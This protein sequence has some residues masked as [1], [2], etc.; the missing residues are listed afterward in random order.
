MKKTILKA[1]FKSITDICFVVIF[2]DGETIVY[3]SGNPTIKIIF[4]R[5]IAINFNLIDPVLLF[6][7]AYADG[8]IDIEGELE[9]V[10]SFIQQKKEHPE[11][12]GH[13]KKMLFHQSVNQVSTNLL[14]KKQKL[15]IQRHYDLGNDFFSLWLDETMNYS[16]AYFKNQDNTLTEAQLN[17]IDLILKKLH[18]KSGERL[19]D[20]GCGW[21]SLIIRAVQQYN[22]KAIG[23]TI[24]DEQYRNV[25]E[26]IKK[27]GLED[28]LEVRLLHYMDLP[29]DQQLFDKIVS[30]GMF[31]HVG[32]ENLG[33]YMEKVNNLLTPGGLSLLH[34]ITG[35]EEDSVNSWIEKYIFPGG[36][37]PSLRETIW[38]LPQYDF[39]LIHV[40]SLRMHYAMTL[41]RW[42]ENFNKHLDEI[43]IKFDDRFI[44]MWSLY[45]RGSAA[46]FRASGLNVHQIL[47]SKGLNN[48]LPLTM[49]NIYC[50][51]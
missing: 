38:L 28:M 20:I 18:L 14:R 7:E 34:T 36:Y 4:N 2:W 29:G 46:S 5:E 16:C 39:H 15:D 30:V 24:S 9:A 50:G 37:I 13:L 22:V 23:I 33:K 31:E 35:T 3:G 43:R 6:G 10:I 25:K 48:N 19:L 21:G 1:F 26:K 8:T 32:R 11:K 41:D 40:E 51:N 45:L 47:I 17:K 42:Y 49:E 27:L 12:T 44:R